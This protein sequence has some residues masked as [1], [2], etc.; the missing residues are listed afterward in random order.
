MISFRA[1][2]K[3]WKPVFSFKIHT[4]TKKT[5][6]FTIDFSRM[7]TVGKCISAL[8][9]FIIPVSCEIEVP[10]HSSPVQWSPVQSSPV[11]SS[12]ELEVEVT[13]HFDAGPIEETILCLPPSEETTWLCESQFLPQYDPKVYICS[14]ENSIDLNRMEEHCVLADYNIHTWSCPTLDLIDYVEQRCKLLDGGPWTGAT[15]G[16]PLSVSSGASGSVLL[17]AQFS[18]SCPQKQ[19]C[20]NQRLNKCCGLKKIGRQWKCPKFC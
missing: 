9:L 10:I 19:I 3:T 12:P 1:S 16:E 5:N 2:I 15:A 4:Y 8:M 14:G 18:D 20:L 13:I 7:K 6:Q 11:Q 17:S